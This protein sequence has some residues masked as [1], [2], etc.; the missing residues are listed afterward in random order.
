MIIYNLFVLFRY[1]QPRPINKQSSA[2]G[3]N[4]IVFTNCCVSY[5][6]PRTRA[7]AIQHSRSR[8]SETSCCS[9]NDQARQHSSPSKHSNH[10]QPP[11]PDPSHYPTDFAWLQE[12]GCLHNRPLPLHAV[13]SQAER[14]NR[15]RGQV[16]KGLHESLERRRI[17]YQRKRTEKECTVPRAYHRG[18]D[19]EGCSHRDR[20][21]RLQ[22]G[23]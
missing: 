9:P 10:I 21:L 13:R 22:I 6:T 20:T 11:R 2:G 19:E 7:R 23:R 18:R 16:R 15:H 4:L 1:L 3:K 14:S 17:H 8:T 12:P 5:T